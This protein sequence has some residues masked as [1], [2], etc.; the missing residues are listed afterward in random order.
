MVSDKDSQSGDHNKFLQFLAEPNAIERMASL[1]H[2]TCV[3]D[4]KPERLDDEINYVADQ[5]VR[6]AN[7][8]N[9]SDSNLEIVDKQI[10]AY[11]A[12]GRMP[13]VTS[14]VLN[15]INNVSELSLPETTDSFQNMV[16]M[17]NE[18]DKQQS[19][20]AK[21]IMFYAVGMAEYEWR[22]RLR[23]DSVAY[24]EEEHGAISF[25]TPGGDI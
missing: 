1:V 9:I 8:I 24:N 4:V 21:A 23:G 3:K 17:M 25:S 18:L 13:E 5:I 7:S 16:M 20:M 15:N 11:M 6:M 22:D 19:E 12:E 2:S 14:Y 10:H